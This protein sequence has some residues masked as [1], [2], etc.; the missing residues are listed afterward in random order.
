MLPQFNRRLQTS[1]SEN[2]TRTHNRLGFQV[3]VDLQTNKPGS[4][5]ARTVIYFQI[6]FKSN[7]CTKFLTQHEF[8]QCE[9]LQKYNKVM[10]KKKKYYHPVYGFAI[11][12]SNLEF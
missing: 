9:A 2:K 1:W 10:F 8:H 5:F 7:H 4:V 3:L 6:S 12:K 11:V